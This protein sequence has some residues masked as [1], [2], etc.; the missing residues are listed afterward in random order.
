MPMPLW[1][2]HVN[3]RVFNQREIRKGNR[4]VVTHVGRSSGA[5]YHTPLDAHSVDGGYIFILVYGSESDWVRNIMASGTA[6]L[7]KDGESLDLDSPRVITKET[8]WQ[9]LDPETKPPPEILKIT[10]Y[11][12]MDVAG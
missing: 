3:K 8:A 7:K 12:Q 1:W 9:Q 2:G 4:P 11:L 5:T 6:T 10:E